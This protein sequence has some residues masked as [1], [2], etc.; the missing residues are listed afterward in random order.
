MSQFA[1]DTMNTDFAA[2]N[3][4]LVES[5]APEGSAAPLT[6]AQALPRMRMAALANLEDVERLAK[7]GDSMVCCA[8]AELLRRR[9]GVLNGGR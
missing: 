1:T 4:A 8:S 7:V 2:Q 5:A 6:F 9:R 3:R